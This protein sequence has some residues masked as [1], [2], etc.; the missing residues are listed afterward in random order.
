MNLISFLTS[1]GILIKFFLLSWGTK[2]V[3]IPVIQKNDN[4]ITG[5]MVKDTQTNKSYIGFIIGIIALIAVFSYIFIP[6][7]ENRGIDTFTSKIDTYNDLLRRYNLLKRDPRNRDLAQK[8]LPSLKK[9]YYEILI[10][11]KLKEAEEY[12]KTT[13][14]NW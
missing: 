12:E 1:L 5:N 4:S 2:T 6:R 10:E 13:E 3:L 14:E 11:Q 7:T 8:M 9:L